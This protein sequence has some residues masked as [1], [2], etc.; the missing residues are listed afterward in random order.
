MFSKTFTSISQLNEHK[1]QFMEWKIA[2][3]CVPKY[4]HQQR[5]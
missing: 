3:M 5:N 1:K 2:V 4:S